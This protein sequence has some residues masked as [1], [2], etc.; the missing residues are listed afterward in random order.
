MPWTAGYAIR[1]EDVQMLEIL[2]ERTTHAEAIA[3]LR[4][5]IEE[6]ATTLDDYTAP[7]EAE[8]DR[9][10][11]AQAL[12]RLRLVVVDAEVRIHGSGIDWFVRRDA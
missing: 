8:L 5:A 3:A 4:A 9:A 12:R 7:H 6:D 2:A 1:N 11:F 10:I